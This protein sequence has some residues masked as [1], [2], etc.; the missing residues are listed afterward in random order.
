MTVTGVD[1][2]FLAA[3]NKNKNFK[4]FTYISLMQWCNDVLGAYLGTHT[5]N[6]QYLSLSSGLIKVTHCTDASYMVCR[7]TE[8]LSIFSKAM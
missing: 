3:S 1:Y 7:G 8:K 5:F 4:R 6:L 2:A